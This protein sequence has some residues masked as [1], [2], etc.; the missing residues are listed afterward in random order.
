MSG[1]CCPVELS[2]VLA[3][4]FRQT[5]KELLQWLESKP[6]TLDLGSFQTVKG[7]C[8]CHSGDDFGY[9]VGVCMPKRLSSYSAGNAEGEEKNSGATATVALARRD[10]IVVANVG[11]SRAV[12]SR[13]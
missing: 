10:K 12:L 11:D 3:D 6:S 1:L 5:D 13:R 4:S 8:F 2:A 7:R 9:P